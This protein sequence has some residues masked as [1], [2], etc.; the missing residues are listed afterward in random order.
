MYLFNDLSVLFDKLL[1]QFQNTNSK[2]IYQITMSKL[3]YN[4]FY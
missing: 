2:Y 4:I 3:M 1:I